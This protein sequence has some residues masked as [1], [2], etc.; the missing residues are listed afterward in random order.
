MKILSN[1][2]SQAKQTYDNELLEIFKSLQEND[3]EVA[4]AV[5]FLFDDALD[6]ATFMAKPHSL[7]ADKSPL[8]AIE[9]GERQDVLD[10]IY[11]IQHGLPQ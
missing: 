10:L 5:L 2:A 11:R 6:A 4:K 3:P 9:D 7:F 8:K 1:W